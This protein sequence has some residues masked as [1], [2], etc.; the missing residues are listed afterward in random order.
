MKVE[1]SVEMGFD[2]F[3]GCWVTGFA[4]LNCGRSRLPAAEAESD[5]LV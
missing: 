3:L 2:Y 4:S 5:D 1:V